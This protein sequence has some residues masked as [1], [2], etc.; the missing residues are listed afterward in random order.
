MQPCRSPRKASRGLGGIMICY[1]CKTTPCCPASCILMLSK[2]SLLKYRHTC[3]RTKERNH[4]LLLQLIQLR[5]TGTNR[6]VSK[7]I[8][9]LLGLMPTYKGWAQGSQPSFSCLR[10]EVAKRPLGL[11]VCIVPRKGAAERVTRGWDKGF[12]TRGFGLHSWIITNFPT[13]LLSRS[14]PRFPTYQK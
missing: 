2:G 7:G 6:V 11:L 10:L 8:C 14:A 13:V 9:L 3:K 1:R 5:Q 4:H 12:G